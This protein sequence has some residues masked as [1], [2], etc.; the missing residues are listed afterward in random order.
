MDGAILYFSPT[1][2]TEAV[3]RV[4]GSA[5]QL[6]VAYDLTLP[7][8]LN[9]QFAP[10]DVCVIGVP[11][12]GGRVPSTALDRLNQVS[13]NGARAVIVASY[14]NRAVDDTLLE[15]QDV[16]TQKGFVVMAAVM[17]VTE[18]SIFRQFA[19]GRPNV[20]DQQEL[21]HFAEQI[22]Q[23]LLSSDTTEPISVPGNRPFREYNGVPLK[24]A[25]N[26]KCNNCGLC[27]VRCPVGAIDPLT[28]SKTD[29]ERCISCMRCI[30]IC[31]QKARKI[32]PLL[33]TAAAAKMHKEF[34]TPK[35]NCLFL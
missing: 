24:P 6:S 13:G 15:L 17:A 31:P 30:A 35:A 12:Y 14:G 16:L 20:Q 22:R 32:N 7:E 21:T 4:I 33:L 19:A 3:C 29:K 28:P 23:K 10:E 5:L 18:H 9:T 34:E 27:A 1:G 25:T 2:G 11:V 8:P 26:S